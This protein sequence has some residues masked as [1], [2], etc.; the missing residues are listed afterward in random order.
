[1][2]LEPMIYLKKI[3]KSND[4]QLL[5]LSN[6]IVQ[7]IFLDKTEIILS[8]ES[9]MVTYVDKE[10]QRKKYPINTAMESRNYQMAKR[11]KLTKE[12]LTKMVNQKDARAQ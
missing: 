4:A 7:V 9:K 2:R 6:K 8:Q 10:G 1:M 3:I 12:I 5:R 11:L